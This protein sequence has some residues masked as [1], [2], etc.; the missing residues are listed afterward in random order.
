[1]RG[2]VKVNNSARSVL[3]YHQHVKQ[4]KSRARDDA[5]VTGDDGRRVILQKGGPALVVAPVAAWR[6]R[7]LWQV[8][9]DRARRDAQ[10]E[11]QQQFVCN[12]L[13][14]PRGILTR[15]AG[16]GANRHTGSARTDRILSRTNF[17]G[18]R[19]TPFKF[20]TISPVSSHADNFCGAQ[21]SANSYDETSDGPN[22]VMP[23]TRSKSRS[24]LAKF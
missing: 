19:F 21:T 20:V 17:L 10:A 16:S 11:F 14:T 1:M 12:A 9:V 8:L 4:P 23:A 13:L 6:G 7:R 5:E 24:A 22:T 2:H 15:A 18:C 3:H